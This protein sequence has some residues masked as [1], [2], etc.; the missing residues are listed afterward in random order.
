MTKTKCT[1]Y[2]DPDEW[3]ALQAAARERAVEEQTS[4]S[5][6]DILRRAT[7]HY[8]AEWHPDIKR[9][10]RQRTSGK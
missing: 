1:V 5:A 4:V 3:Q 9:S 7:A 6:S 10:K 2:F 8:L